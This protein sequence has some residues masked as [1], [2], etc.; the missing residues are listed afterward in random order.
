MSEIHLVIYNGGRTFVTL[1]SCSVVLSSAVSG[2]GTD[3]LWLPEHYITENSIVPFKWCIALTHFCHYSTQTS[4][5]MLSGRK[6]MF[7]FEW[8]APTVT[9]SKWQ[10]ALFWVRGGFRKQERPRE[11]ASSAAGNH[12]VLFQNKT[13]HLDSVKQ[14]RGFSLYLCF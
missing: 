10:L 3:P 7:H 8:N 2:K 11:S 1:A 14:L 12:S 9:H 5:S 6:F 13:S 4:R